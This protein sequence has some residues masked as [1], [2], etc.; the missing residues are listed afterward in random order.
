MRGCRVNRGLLVLF[1]LALTACGGSGDDAAT[2]VAPTGPV[3]S[4]TAPTTTAAPAPT[5]APTTT[6]AETTTTSVDP[7]AALVEE[8][9]DLLA[10]EKMG[11]ALALAVPDSGLAVYLSA[12]QLFVDQVGAQQG[13]VSGGDGTYTV[14]WEDQQLTF[15]D[16]VIESGLIADM[17]RDGAPLSTTVAAS[18]ATYEAR[19]ITGTVHS[20]RYFDGNLQVVVTAVNNSDDEGYLGFGDYVTGGREF[21]NVFSCSIRPT[22]TST[23]IVAFEDVPPGAGTL[24]GNLWYGNGSELEVTLDVPALG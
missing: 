12:A 7:G 16:F 20:F 3:A 9:V 11:D 24:Y 22:V 13:V 4:T 1:V 15:S 21:T 23:Y 2:T 10:A 5:D 14:R 8:F 17:A 19:G 18:G 6:E